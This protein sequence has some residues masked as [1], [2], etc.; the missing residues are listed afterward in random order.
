MLP[1]LRPTSA[2]SIE[3]AEHMSLRIIGVHQTGR[4]LTIGL[5][6]GIIIPIPD[7]RGIDRIHRH[8]IVRHIV[9]GIDS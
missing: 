7:Q 4:F 8:P 6:G 2:G 1:K 9:A 3:A 5:R